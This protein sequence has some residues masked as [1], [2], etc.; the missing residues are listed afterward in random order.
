MRKWKIDSITLM[1]YC[2]DKILG[3]SIK[4]HINV[5]SAIIFEIGSINEIN[6]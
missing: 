6:K 1:D 3:K 5:K 2:R 4:I